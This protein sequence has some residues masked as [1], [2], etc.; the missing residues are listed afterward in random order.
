MIIPGVQKPHWR[1][2]FSQ[3]AAWSGWRSSP[4]A[5]PSMVVTLAPSAW[6]ASTVHD[7]TAMP[8]RWIG[9]GAA[10]AGVAADMRACQVEVLADG[11]DEEASG[12][13]LELVT[14]P[15]DGQGDVFTHGPDLLRRRRA[16]GGDRG[17]G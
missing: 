4:D 12:F 2:C 9:A 13:D 15:V 6:T 7:F 16:T 1:P 5:M 17:S 11:L 10:L 8:S 14:C 3:K